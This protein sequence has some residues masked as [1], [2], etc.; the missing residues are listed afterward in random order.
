M[1]QMNMIDINLQQIIDLLIAEHGA[2]TILLYGSRADGSATADSDYDMA[3]FALVAE[4]LRDN[5]FAEGVYRDIF[6]YP[7]V[8]LNSPSKDYLKLCDSQIILQRDSSA[9][10]FLAQL[11]LILQA[12]PKIL[13]QQEIQVRYQ[14]AI[15]MCS[16]LAR[17]DIEGNYRRIML[18]MTLLEDYFDLRQRWYQGSK[19]AFLWLQKNSPEDFILFDKALS[20]CATQQE[21]EALVVGVFNI[22]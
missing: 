17:G 22:P 14:W 15:K 12:G 1:L 19:K 6:I 11:N 8:I 3:A 20:P 18:L 21:I 16:R 13:S 10:D 9:S 2:H 5:R 4:E 7:D